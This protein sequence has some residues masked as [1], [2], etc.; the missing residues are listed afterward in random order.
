MLV[1]L[2]EVGSSSRPAVRTDQ[3]S[4]RELMKPRPVSSI[5][6]LRPLFVEH[7]THSPWESTGYISIVGSETYLKRTAYPDSDSSWYTSMPDAS[8]EGAERSMF[9]VDVRFSDTLGI[10]PYPTAFS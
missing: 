3:A 8:N 7:T 4:F 1:H 9:P 2:L 5:F 6:N 10:H